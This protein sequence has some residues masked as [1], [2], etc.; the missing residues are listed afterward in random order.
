MSNPSIEWE[1]CTVLS[2]MNKRV[3]SWDL[4]IKS[5]QSKCFNVPRQFIRE[6]VDGDADDDEPLWL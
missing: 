5:D 1:L 3:I 4:E 6:A 2:D